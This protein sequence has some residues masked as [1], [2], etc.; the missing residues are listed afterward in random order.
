MMIEN[1]IVLSA[2]IVPYP[3][4]QAAVIRRMNDAAYLNVLAQTIHTYVYMC[5]SNSHCG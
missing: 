3:I 2:Q 4:S 5:V 1:V